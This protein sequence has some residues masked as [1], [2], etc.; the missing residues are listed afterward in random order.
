[1]SEH[2]GPRAQSCLCAPGSGAGPLA[3]QLLTGPWGLSILMRGRGEWEDFL[4]APPPSIYQNYSD[5]ELI[6]YSDLNNK[7][8]CM[9]L[10]RPERDLIIW[11]TLG[12]K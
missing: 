2:T 5:N 11:C 6:L 4:H 7:L 3:C 9:I 10:R 1:M 12:W 8:I